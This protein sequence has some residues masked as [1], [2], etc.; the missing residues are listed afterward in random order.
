LHNTVNHDVLNTG[1]F[2]LG[3]LSNKNCIN[4]V[5]RSLVPGDRSAGPDI[6]E[7]VE[8]SPKGKV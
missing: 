2:S 7:E 3:V 8:C 4:T 1:I 5:I 6:G